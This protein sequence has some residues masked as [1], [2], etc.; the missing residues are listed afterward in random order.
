MRRNKRV[1]I[2]LAGCL[3]FMGAGADG[4]EAATP[5][6]GVVRVEVKPFALLSAPLSFDAQTSAVFSV[7]Y[8]LIDRI[9]LAPGDVK[10]AAL[11]LA[12]KP[13]PRRIAPLA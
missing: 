6:D 9:A 8:P 5:P 4:G 7:N 1:W 10:D 13:L 3:F 11:R 12:V 2:L